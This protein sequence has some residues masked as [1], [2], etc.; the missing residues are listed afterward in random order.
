[1]HEA[2]SKIIEFKVLFSLAKFP[3]NIQTGLFEKVYSAKKKDR[4]LIE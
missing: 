3:V 4:V 2:A 1:M